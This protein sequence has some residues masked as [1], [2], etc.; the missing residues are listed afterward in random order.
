MLFLHFPM[1]FSYCPRMLVYR[2]AVFLYHSYV[3]GIF[4]YVP[5]ENPIGQSY[6]MMVG[7]F[8]KQIY[9]ETIGFFIC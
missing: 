6:E 1:A 8:E 3:F 9:V 5:S 7:P 4:L 2:P